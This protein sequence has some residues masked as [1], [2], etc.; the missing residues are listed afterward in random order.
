MSATAAHSETVS[1]ET[2]TASACLGI[3]API[4]AL[5]VG[6]GSSSS[7]WLPGGIQPWLLEGASAGDVP[8]EAFGAGTFTITRRMSR[9]MLPLCLMLAAVPISWHLHVPYGVVLDAAA[10][11]TF[12]LDT[13]ELYNASSVGNSS[14]LSLSSL[15]YHPDMDAELKPFLLSKVAVNRGGSSASPPDNGST[16]SEGSRTEDD[17][18]AAVPANERWVPLGSRYVEA[19]IY[20][21]CAAIHD[22]LPLVIQLE[23]AVP[24]SLDTAASIISLTSVVLG[25][26]AAMGSTIP[27]LSMMTC[28]GG[29]GIAFVSQTSK[30]L[31]SVFY[32]LSPTAVV[33]GNLG[34]IIALALVHGALAES[35]RCWRKRTAPVAI[36]RVAE[37]EDDDQDENLGAA[38]FHHIALSKPSFDENVW[39]TARYPSWTIKFGE[40]LIPGVLF[41]AIVLFTTETRRSTASSDAVAAA[42]VVGVV[43]CTSAVVYVMMYT[44]LWMPRFVRPIAQWRLYPVDASTHQAHP[45]FGR[46]ALLQRWFPRGILSPS[47]LRLSWGPIVG[48]MR[49][50]TQRYRT[51]EL[52]LSLLPAIGAGLSAAGAA[53]STT[54]CLSVV[55]VLGV[56]YICVAAYMSWLRPYR[57]PLDNL[58]CPFLYGSIG[59]VLIV[60]MTSSTLSR[61]PV[62]DEGVENALLLAGSI[63]QLLQS[64]AQ[65]VRTLASQYILYV[66]TATRDFPSTEENL[67]TLIDH[68]DDEELMPVIPLPVVGD[69]VD[70]EWLS[71][72]GAVDEPPLRDSTSLHQMWR[73]LDQAIHVAQ[74][75]T[76]ALTDLHPTEDADMDG[77]SGGHDGLLREWGIGTTMIVL[78]QGGGVPLQSPSTTTHI[79]HDDTERTTTDKEDNNAFFGIQGYFN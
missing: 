9:R 36:V 69:D 15:M 34:L 29:E 71:G 79:L 22:P 63:V 46:S 32:D 43:G 53:V 74:D 62:G 77:G 45:A 25:G 56:L 40:L 16:S 20:V 47:T 64:I 28:D 18:D 65:F 8:I 3:A 70:L 7:S 59:V 44:V 37:A 39:S 50:E 61:E 73:A 13:L 35:L 11:T 52:A 58:I 5:P 78:G 72:G 68:C 26:D 17:I 67:E 24:D 10:T 6:G 49:L 54:A 27:M 41:G 21:A 42:S 4:A 1:S 14:S 19:L 38:S 48:S 33:I 30:I 66:E 23:Q 51:A 76:L 2:M 75:D 31:V 55:Y 12:T 57:M 60:K